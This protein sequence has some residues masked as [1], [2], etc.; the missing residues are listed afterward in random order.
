MV[1]VRR[2]GTLSP[3]L[4]LWLQTMLSEG[5]SVAGNII[6]PIVQTIKTLLRKIGWHLS[7]CKPQ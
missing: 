7:R 4:L 3:L 6:A 5:I 2:R 1:G